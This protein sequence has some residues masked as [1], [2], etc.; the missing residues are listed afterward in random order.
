[1]RF[2]FISWSLALAAVLATAA[3]SSA[4]VVR[5]H[6]TPAQLCGYQSTNLK[7][8]MDGSTGEWKSFALSPATQPYYSQLKPTHLVTFRHPYTNQN[9]T[10][11]LAFPVGTPRVAIQNDAVVYTYTQYT[12]RVEFLPDGSVDTVYNS[13]IFRPLQP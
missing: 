12:I 4:E 8:G 9:V 7:V 3:I 2:N 11:P 13:G 6:Y 10:V 1:M 5:F